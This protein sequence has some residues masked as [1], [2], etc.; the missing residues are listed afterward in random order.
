M[1]LSSDLDGFKD[2]MERDLAE[3]AALSPLAAQVVADLRAALVREANSERNLNAALREELRWKDALTRAS[4][5]A[6]AALNRADRLESEVEAKTAALRQLNA[7]RDPARIA[8][9]V[10]D[11]REDATRDAGIE[12]A[13]LKA[14]LGET[15]SQLREALEAK[16]RLREALNRMKERK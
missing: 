4:R 2:R 16:R 1:V 12:I 9:Q 5:D 14:K 11:A 3:V 10:V 8:R 15:E 7:E 6:T 13:T